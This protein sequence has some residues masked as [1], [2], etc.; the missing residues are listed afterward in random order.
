MGVAGVKI[1]MSVSINDIKDALFKSG[2]NVRQAS[3]SLSICKN[4]VYDF[5]NEH[6]LH[7]YLETCRARRDELLLDG[8]FAAMMHNLEKIEKEPRI[9]LDTAKLALEYRGYKVG[10]VKQQAEKNDTTVNITI[11][12]MDYSKAANGG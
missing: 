2:G 11:N 1:E 9:A 6:N 4:V 12:S 7:E 8:S 3:R 10:W 5:I